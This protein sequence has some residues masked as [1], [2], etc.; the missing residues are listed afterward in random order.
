MY[1]LPSI[2]FMKWMIVSFL[3]HYV[4]LY[5]LNFA[6]AE[7]L[8][9]N[10]NCT[11]DCGKKTRLIFLDFKQNESK[12]DRLYSIQILS[13]VF[14][15]AF[16]LKQVVGGMDDQMPSL[17]SS[18]GVQVITYSKL[19]GQVIAHPFLSWYPWLFLVTWTKWCFFL[20]HLFV[21]IS[22]Y[23]ISLLFSLSLPGSHLALCIFFFFWRNLFDG[24]IQG[25]LTC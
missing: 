12:S 16:P 25:T 14:S 19:L 6:V 15:F 18:T 8:V 22:E 4:S 1:E 20:R 2:P 7:L 3:L 21:L 17:P 11:F 24:Y 23:V 9:W 5:H 13:L 10:F